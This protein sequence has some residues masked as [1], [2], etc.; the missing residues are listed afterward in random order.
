MLIC[1]VPTF[2]TT[3]VGFKF[4]SSL[5]SVIVPAAPALDVMLMIPTGVYPSTFGDV[6]VNRPFVFALIVA[7]AEV[8]LVIGIVF[9]IV[10]LAIGD[11]SYQTYL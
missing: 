6:P 8:V 2:L 5:N 3:D 10:L 7:V 4:P 9:L 1:E 11:T